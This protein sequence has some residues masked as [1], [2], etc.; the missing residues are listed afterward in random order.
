LVKLTASD[1]GAALGLWEDSNG[2]VQ[3]YEHRVKGNFVRVVNKDGK[4]Q[5]LKP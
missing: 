4:E 1:E 3:L 2:G 5:V